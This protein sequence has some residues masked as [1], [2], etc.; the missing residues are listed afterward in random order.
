[1]E[2]N[3]SRVVKKGYLC[4][5]VISSLLKGLSE[6]ML[7][8]TVT[9]ETNE[10]VNSKHGIGAKIHYIAFTILLK[11]APVVSQAGKSRCLS[12][13]TKKYSCIKMYK[14]INVTSDVNV[15]S[16]SM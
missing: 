10:N 16:K 12:P 9:G 2:Q 14:L 4:F 11:C 7:G 13:V 1:M 3:L 8:S 15:L 5:T 6:C